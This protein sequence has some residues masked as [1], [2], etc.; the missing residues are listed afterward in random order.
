M[1]LDGTSGPTEGAIF[2]KGQAIKKK[3]EKELV[4][5]NLLDL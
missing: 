4:K 2:T 5:K 3:I 1:I